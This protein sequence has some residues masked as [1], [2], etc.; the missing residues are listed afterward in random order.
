M[1]NFL[2]T[3]KPDRFRVDSNGQ[4]WNSYGGR[5]I[6][7]NPNIPES[8]VI[9][10]TIT[11]EWKSSSP[12]PKPLLKRQQH[13]GEETLFDVKDEPVLFSLDTHVDD[14][15]DTSNYPDGFLVDRNGEAWNRSGGRL[16]LHNGCF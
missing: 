8:Y 13:Y 10:T 4:A 1:S 16:V 6:V 11:P 12:L 7:A 9:D 2:Q 5:L 3:T 15:I 14:S